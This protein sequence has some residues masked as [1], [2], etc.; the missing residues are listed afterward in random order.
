LLASPS[1]LQKELEGFKC[2]VM[3]FCPSGFTSDIYKVMTGE[4]IDRDE[5][6][7]IKAEDLAELIFYLLRLPKR[8]EIASIFVNR[9]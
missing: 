2:R 8:I 3:D 7:Q 5:S 6:K 4:K 9:K 1:D